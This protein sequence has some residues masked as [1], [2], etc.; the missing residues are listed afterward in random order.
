MSGLVGSSIRVISVVEKSEKKNISQVL[1]EAY[2]KS[3]A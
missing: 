1:N 3:K 2:A